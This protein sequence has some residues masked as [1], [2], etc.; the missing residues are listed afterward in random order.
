MYSGVPVASSTWAAQASE[1][2]M[3]VAVTEEEADC[4]NA[5]AESSS[6]S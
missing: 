1:Q 5:F 2:R 3:M 4:C 6:M